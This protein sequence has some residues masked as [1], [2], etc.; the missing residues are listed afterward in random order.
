MFPRKPITQAIISKNK[1]VNNKESNEVNKSV[2]TY[3]NE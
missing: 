1:K 2:N 3:A